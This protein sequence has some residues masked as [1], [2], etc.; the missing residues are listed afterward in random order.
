M[1]N[2][3]WT[4]NLDPVALDLGFLQIHWYGVMYAL[5]FLAGYFFLRYA[6]KTKSTD[7]TEQQIDLLVF[8]VAGGVIVGGRL[9][10]FLFYDFQ[11]LITDPLQF[12]TVWRGGMSFHGG[13]IGVITALYFAARHFKKPLLELSDLILIPTALGLFFGRLGNFIN[14]E[15]WGVPT[16]ADWGVVFPRA[17]ELPRHPSQ[18]YEAAKNLLIFGVLLRIWHVAYNTKKP[19]LI[20]FSFLTLYGAGRIIVEQFWRAPV[21]GYILGLTTGQFWSV[22]VLLLGVSGL[23]MRW[24]S[25]A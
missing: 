1:T 4:H 5:A 8:A 25:R 24:R 6:S 11:T 9:G 16:E 21:D 7:L 18:L 3:I 22:P 17:G 20:S 2:F 13:L 15:L 14:G 23:I 19:G 12:F 10:H